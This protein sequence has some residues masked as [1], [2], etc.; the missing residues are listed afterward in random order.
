VERGDKLRDTDS[1]YEQAFSLIH[2]KRMGRA[3][4]LSRE[5]DA[6]RDRYGRHL[7]G[8]GVLLARRLIEAELPLVTVYWNDPTPAGAG[9]GEYDSHGRIYWHMRNRLVPPTDR[10]LAA[11]FED[12]SQ[13]GLLE[14]TLVVTMAEFGRTPR[15]NGQAGRDHWPQAASILLAGAGI[16]GGTIY[17]ATDRHA[18]YPA[19]NPVTPPDLGQTILHLLGVP[20]DLELH[21]QQGRPVPACRGSQIPALYS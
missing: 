18:A 12:M 14:D 4:D 19:S 20:S 17:G 2:S 11:L 8:Q 1:Y 5:S 10:A 21:D 6:D 7:F 13:R 15:I 3:L 9:G 16:S